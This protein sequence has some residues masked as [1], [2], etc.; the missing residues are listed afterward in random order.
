[1]RN[2]GVCVIFIYSMGSLFEKLSSNLLDLGARNKL[3]NFKDQKL[4]SLEIINPLPNDI[5]LMLNDDKTLRFVR[6]DLEGVEPDEEPTEDSGDLSLIQELDAKEIVG[7]KRGEKYDRTLKSIKRFNDSVMTEK[8]ISVLYM[9]F[10]LVKWTQATFSRY[11]LS[12]PLLLIPVELIYNRFD[13]TYSVKRVEDEVIVN[14]ALKSKF[15]IEF[16]VSIPDFEEDDDFDSYFTKIIDLADQNN[17]EV[18]DKVFVGIFS[19]AKL[20]MYKD[21]KNNEK[22]METR[23]IID[24]IFNGKQQAFNS[25]INTNYDE[26]FKNSEELK[27]VNVVDADSSQIRA[28]QEAKNGKSFVIQGPPGTGKSQTITNIIAELIHDGKNVLFVSEKISALNVVY[29]NLKK[30]GLDSFCLQLHSD[31]TKKKDFVEELYHIMKNPPLGGSKADS[32]LAELKKYKK[33]LDDYSD[34]I[35]KVMPVIN[36]RPYDIISRANS[37]K[38]PNLNYKID[39]IQNKGLEHLSS[40]KDLLDRYATYKDGLADHY[41]ESPWYGFYGDKYLYSEKDSLKELFKQTAEWLEE[42][43]ASIDKLEQLIEIDLSSLEQVYKCR[44]ELEGFAHLAICDAN[45]FNSQKAKKIS[46]E[47]TKYHNIEKTFEDKFKKLTSIVDKGIFELDIVDLYKKY[48]GEYKSIFRAFNSKYKADASLINSFNNRPNKLGFSEQQLVVKLAYEL[49]IHKKEL[50]ELE[51]SVKKN[52]DY[53]YFEQE[54]LEEVINNVNGFVSANSG[55]ITF[56][57]DF[58]E[59]AFRKA[60]EDASKVLECLDKESK[61]VDTLQTFFDVSVFDIKKSELAVSLEKVKACSS[62]FEY[63]NDWVRFYDLFNEIKKQNLLPFIEEC[64][65]NGLD[66]IKM[67][68]AYAHIYYTTW[69][70]HV[71]YLEPKLSNFRRNNQDLFVKKYIEL[72]KKGFIESRLEIVTKQRDKIKKINDTIYYYPGTNTTLTAQFTLI[73]KEANK[74]R[75]VKPIRVMLKEAKDIIKILKPCFLMSPL[76]VAS[77]MEYNPNAFDVVIFDEASQIFPWDAIGAIA[78]SKQVIVVGDS[79]QMPPTNFFMASTDNFDEDDFEEYED[80]NAADYESILD[81]CSAVLPFTLL[82]WHYRSRNEAL[83]AFSNHF[84]YGDRLVTFPSQRIEGM[85]LGIDF[86]YVKDATFINR[87]NRKEADAVVDLIYKHFENHPERSLGV[88]CFSINQQA[89]L[90]DVLEDRRRKDDRFARY[91][92]S[93]VKEPFFIKNLETV[94]G[95]ERDTIIFSVGYGKDASGNLK[96]NFGPLNRVGGERRLNVAVTRAKYNVKVVSSLHAYDFDLNRTKAVGAKLLKDYLEVAENGLAKLNREINVN[97]NA[98]ADSPF[99]EEVANFIRSE[100]YKVDLQVGCSGFKID[101]CVKHPEHNDYV[102]AIECDGATYHS[103]KDTRDRDRLRQ[104]ILERLGWKFYRIWSTDWFINLRN[105]KEYLL[106]AIKSA[107][108][109]YD[110]VIKA[111]EERKE[112]E[113]QERFA[114]VIKKEEAEKAKREYDDLDFTCKIDESQ[115]NIIFA[116]ND[117]LA[118]KN[119]RFMKADRKNIYSY[120]VFDDVQNGLINAWFWFAKSGGDLVFKYRDLPREASQVKTVNAF[121]LSSVKLIID[122]LIED[123]YNAK[124]SKERA[125]TVSTRTIKPS[126]DVSIPKDRNDNLLIYYS[127]SKTLRGKISYYSPKEKELVLKICDFVY[128]VICEDA[129]RNHYFKNKE[130][131]DRYKHSRRVTYSFFGTSFSLGSVTVEHARKM[132]LYYKASCLITK[133]QEY[134]KTMGVQI[135][136]NY[137]EL[138]ES[139]AD[140]I[141]DNDYAFSKAKGVNSNLRYVDD[142]VLEAELEKFKIFE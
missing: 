52:S 140:L 58:N 93:S 122:R 92:E 36:L 44:K 35:Y 101:M 135:V 4:K 116:V 22:L 62:K 134:E 49:K 33:E 43:K 123:R 59:D 46:D 142:S 139:L 67:A 124:L 40:V 26:Y 42:L 27:L 105:E 28:I 110:A 17:W 53:P 97:V 125:E 37:Y 108:N 2:I 74:K 106:S 45:L 129:I 132:Y 60:K 96:H 111:E 63:I 55:Q 98:E 20:T 29:N 3:L 77:Y 72:D 126:I 23:P 9:S 136:T 89:L 10:G 115:R 16:N 70:M 61:R 83:I 80:E 57:E 78:R 112:K 120:R 50:N 79:K 103:S 34:L 138:I 133:I 99:E 6:S 48:H 130:E 119:I 73:A 109:E 13:Q 41:M 71:Y 1:M 118:T 90:E 24:A 137:N 88:V 107:I 54:N 31:K 117:Y 69:M 14:P 5:F 15:E 127:I 128:N 81:L 87:Q 47:L 76:S 114:E 30:V 82:N 38:N 100:G 113:E 65:K 66:V 25:E 121:R 95:D 86:H 32:T 104:E 56:K 21:L 68:E 11:E 85:D 102:L 94:Q 39:D 131:F 7:Y 141:E 8:G 75:A 19:F 18:S 64:L 84:Y 91:F 12:S 51:A